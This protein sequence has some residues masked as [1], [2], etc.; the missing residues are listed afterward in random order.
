MDKR[1]WTMEEKEQTP[2][3]NPPKNNRR[4][5]NW[6]RV[7]PIGSNIRETIEDIRVITGRAKPR[8]EGQEF[9]DSSSPAK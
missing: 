4:K 5:I 2:E 9:S 8:N 7:L 1:I 3:N 6:W